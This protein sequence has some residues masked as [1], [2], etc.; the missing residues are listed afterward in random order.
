MVGFL[1]S[2]LTLLVLL[3]V[4]WQFEI[5]RQAILFVLR[6]IPAFLLFLFGIL[7]YLLWRPVG[8]LADAL[9]EM[10]PVDS[11]GQRVLERVGRNAA[12]PLLAGERLIFA[13]ERWPA[14][15][16]PELYIAVPED[17][18][19]PLYEDGKL[20]GGIGI[21][22]LADRHLTDAAYRSAVRAGFKAGLVV[23]VAIAIFLVFKVFFGVVAFIPALFEGERPIV[24][25]WPNAEPV[26]VSVLALL[27]A[28][29]NSAFADLGANLITV[30]LS[31]LAAIPLA[32]GAGTIISLL[33]L[34]TWMRIKSEPYR[35]VTKDAD[36]RWS[37]RSET[38][39]LLHR[40]FVK[41]IEHATSYLKDATTY[42]AG[43]A[44]GVL[45]T[46]GDLAA[47]VPGQ[48]LMLDRE[49]L[50]QH[51][52]V[53]GGTGEGKTTAMLKPLMRQILADRRF[54]AFLSDA[55]GV[56]W[57]D[58]CDVAAKLGR[59]DDVI[60][61]G[62][63]PGQ[64][65]LDPI[66]SLTP[67]QVA[68]ILRSV[69]RQTSGAAGEDFWPDMAA[70]VIRHALT[71]G[72]AY[73]LS[74]AGRAEREATGVSSYS[75]WWAYRAIVLPDT[76]ERPGPLQAAITKLRQ[77]FE[78]AGKES[79]AAAQRGDR[80]E[81]DRVALAAR[82][83]FTSELSASMEYLQ[84]GWRSMANET[85]TGIIASVTQLLD[86]FSGAATLRERFASG[87]SGS[88]AELGD[89]LDGKIIVNALS[90]IE[91]GLAARLTSILIK[92]ALYRKARVREAEWKATDGRSPQDKPCLVVMDEVQELATVDPASGLSD[93]TFWNVARSS[94]IAGIFATQSLSALV[95]AMGREAAENF[96]QQAR[97]KVFLR[98][99]E[100]ETVEYACW[101]AGEYERNRVFDDQHRESIE[102][103]Q[104]LDGWTP[105][106]PLDED[107]GIEAG[108]Q[109]FF[110]SAAGL[111]NP[112]LLQVARAMSRPTYETDRRFL[113]TDPAPPPG[114]SGGN[115]ARMASLQAAYWRAEDLT[116][117]YRV[118]GN[119]RLPALTSADMIHLGRWH[120]FAQIQRAGA[121]RQ[122]IVS[123]EHEFG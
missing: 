30:L 94:G 22:W 46:R 57:R 32:F 75:L 48:L 3:V 82:A 15:V 14:A 64:K 52:L 73:S 97:S 65:G 56:L 12:D 69:M 116:R 27:G 110:R 121:V 92:S 62:A 122:D 120:A 28:N 85:R 86:G 4:G 1:S 107:E 33:H 17:I 99:E 98:T 63:G 77:D 51:L 93:A 50:F 6:L 21:V 112:R 119:E 91:D 76:A 8:R 78:K 41:Q 34:S 105:F 38:R 20:L 10:F 19:R 111:I 61:I 87:R 9:V 74:E 84:G 108:P 58:A 104:L 109:A 66:A 36:V 71:I 103:R 123:I 60:V 39:Q 96:V 53:F 35:L 70:A 54:G 23:L 79:E 102:Y 113:A 72:F 40:T 49:S 5:V 55:K 101:C 83:I 45:R 115:A 47:P 31:A 25:Q 100:K 44:T 118:Q 67:S 37:F 80:E 13:Q 26:K 106:D 88:D 81:E 7:A 68:A 95:Q 29:L 18:R 117:Q 11:I 24:E 114:V 89:A 59:S 43:L 2:W 16:F 90:S 42:S